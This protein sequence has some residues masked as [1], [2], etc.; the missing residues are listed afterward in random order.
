MAELFFFEQGAE[1]RPPDE[2]RIERVTAVPY[3]DGRRVKLQLVLT[4]FAE[5]P[6]LDIEVVNAAGQ[7][8]ATVDILETMTPTMD[9]TVHLR[10]PQ[11]E[12][13]HRLLVRLYYGEAPPQDV[14]ELSFEI[15]APG[16]VQP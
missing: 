4:P 2:V 8:V 15:A 10:G 13:E 1:P 6:S 16:V 11:P 12:G 14:H 9:L 5:R 3:V 7:S